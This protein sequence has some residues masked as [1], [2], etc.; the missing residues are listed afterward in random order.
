MKRGVKSVW[1]I[2]CFLLKIRRYGLTF[3]LSVILVSDMMDG[4]PPGRELQI[5]Q[6]SVRTQQDAKRAAE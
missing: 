5:G 6:Q 4:T 2:W 1:K 3:L